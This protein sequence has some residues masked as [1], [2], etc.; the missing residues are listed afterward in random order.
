[1]SESRAARLEEIRE[2]VSRRLRLACAFMRRVDYDAMVTLMADVHY[3]YEQLGGE[4]RDQA[5]PLLSSREPE[6]VSS[7]DEPSSGGEPAR[8]AKQ[9][10]DSRSLA[11][12]A[13]MRR[14]WTNR[15]VSVL[16][17]RERTDDPDR[18]R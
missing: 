11:D 9:A 14:L 2:D 13:R 4:S 16:L 5:V 18:G 7:P 15:P 6:V 10:T 8:S 12:D 3:R 17:P 1:M